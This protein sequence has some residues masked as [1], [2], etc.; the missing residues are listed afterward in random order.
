MAL[1]PVPSKSNLM[2][3]IT[4]LVEVGLRGSLLVEA[5]CYKLEFAS[6]NSDKLIEMFSLPNISS[7]NV[8]LRS[9]EPP[10]GMSI[11]SRVR[12]VLKAASLTAILSQWQA[13]VQGY[14]L[15]ID[16]PLYYHSHLPFQF[17]FISLSASVHLPL[18]N[19]QTEYVLHAL[20][21]ESLCVH[22]NNF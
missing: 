19:F 3:K 18:R 8:T 16:V 14:L 22:P 17:F 11:R 20:P 5:L 13:R 1:D 2:H 21:M 15:S 10:T 12:P 9:T 6:F 4:K 7:L